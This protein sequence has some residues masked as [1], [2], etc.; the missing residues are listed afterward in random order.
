MQRAVN[1]ESDLAKLDPMKSR[2]KK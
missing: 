2:I 1:S